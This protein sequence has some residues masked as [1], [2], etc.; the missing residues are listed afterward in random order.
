[1][2]RTKG[3]KDRIRLEFQ[4]KA[5]NIEIGPCLPAIFLVKHSNIIKHVLG[6]LC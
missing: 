5:L 2:A 4:L 1:M 3:R 6:Q